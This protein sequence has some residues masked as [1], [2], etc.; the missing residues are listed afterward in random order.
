V[1][2]GDLDG[3]VG[4]ILDVNIAGPNGL[5]RAFVPLLRR[6]G[7][8]VVVTISSTSVFTGQGSNIAYCGSKAA[9][10]TIVLSLARALE[11]QIRVRSVAPGPSRQGSC[12]GGIAQRRRRWRKPG[13]RG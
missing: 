7:D 4:Q 13:H 5:M 6:S 8:G 3:L 10:D 12:P 9:L 2:H 1:A 11:P